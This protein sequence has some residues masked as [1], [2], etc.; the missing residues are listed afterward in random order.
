IEEKLAVLEL[1]VRYANQENLLI[2]KDSPE[3]FHKL[4]RLFVSENF[5]EI[6]NDLDRLSK[7]YPLLLSPVLHSG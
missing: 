4:K 7:K 1:L 6:E 2:S 5:F 3:F